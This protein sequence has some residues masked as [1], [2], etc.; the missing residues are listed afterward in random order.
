MQ[1]FQDI[2]QNNTKSTIIFA[3]IYELVAMLC[4]PSSLSKSLLMGN[5]NI[6]S[7]IICKK[8]L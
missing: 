6:S 5:N 4:R 3:S 2:I 1:Q 8:V 7:E